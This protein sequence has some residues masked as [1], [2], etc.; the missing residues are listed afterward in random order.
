MITSNARKPGYY[1]IN[2]TGLA[3]PSLATRRP[4]PLVG[5][6]DGKVWWLSRVQAYQFDCDVTVVRPL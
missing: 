6:W 2:W 1:W 5:E 4:G 3:D